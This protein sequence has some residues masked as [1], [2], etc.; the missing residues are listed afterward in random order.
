MKI[1]EVYSSSVMVS[2]LVCL[3]LG[4]GNWTVGALETA[5]YQALL[6]KTTQT[7]LEETYRSFQELD[8]QKNAEVLRRI[9]DDREK[10][11]AA[12]VKLN[13]FFVVLAGGKILFVIGALL[14]LTAAFGLIRRDARMKMNKAVGV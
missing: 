2:G 10:Y 14:S 9:N 5:K 4:I 3:V 12:K 7:G 1:R 6:R 13:F 11:N 8:Q